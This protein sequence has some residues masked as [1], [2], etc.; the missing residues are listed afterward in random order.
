MKLLQVLTTTRASPTALLLHQ[1]RKLLYQTLRCSSHSFS[2]KITTGFIPNVLKKHQLDNPIVSLKNN[3]AN[4]FQSNEGINF[5]VRHKIT[6]NQMIRK[7]PHKKRRRA[8]YRMLEGKPMRKGIVTKLVVIK[9]KK[10]NSAQRKMCKVLLK[11][12]RQVT[13]AIPGIGHNLRE[14][15]EVMIRGGKTRDCPGVKYKVIRGMLD[16][17][18]VANRT[19]SRSK[20][21][22][23]RPRV[24][25][26]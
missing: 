14:H 15:S 24:E 22:V 11:N 7:P 23:K 13:C 18:G 5:Q 9:P 8:K 26:V 17:Q 19:T 12:G 3:D 2:R 20:Y 1:R 10:P 25:S 6:T 16:C 21:G 4:F